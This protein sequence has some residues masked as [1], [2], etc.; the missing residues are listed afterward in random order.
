MSSDGSAS[1]SSEFL[2][3]LENLRQQ[4]YSQVDIARE[5]GVSA[6][7]I[8]DFKSGRRDLTESFAL[9]V[10]QRFGVDAEWLLGR[11]LSGQS[12][13]GASP[14]Y[15]TP[16]TNRVPGFDFPIAGDPYTHPKWD[17]R[18]VDL[19]DAVAGQIAR[20]KWPYVVK[21]GRDDRQG[22]LHN[23]DLVLVSQSVNP[24]AEFQVVKVKKSCFF[25][26]RMPNG[27]WERVAVPLRGPDKPIAGSHPSVGHCVGVI[28]SRLLP[29]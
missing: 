15:E 25:A 12:S 1:V 14:V 28:W 18:L 26:R 11:P 13:L 7:Y 9:R 3:L 21:F 22:R 29:K 24:G 16:R 27:D 4:G 5:L 23:E 10:Q 6:Q 2:E 17:H 19:T 8:T 20:S